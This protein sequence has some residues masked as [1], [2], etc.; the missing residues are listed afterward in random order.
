M[1]FLD[2]LCLNRPGHPLSCSIWKDAVCDCEPTPMPVMAFT[3]YYCPGCGQSAGKVCEPGCKASNIDHAYTEDDDVVA[4]DTDRPPAL[5]RCYW[6]DRAAVE[7]VHGMP[8]CDSCKRRAF[9]R[10]SQ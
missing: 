6:C 10:R 2:T 9:G 4:S 5:G 7:R 1:L 8:A 3:P